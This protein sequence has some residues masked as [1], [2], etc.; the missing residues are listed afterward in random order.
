M[1]N[2]INQIIDKAAG[3]ESL[4][5]VYQEK[6]PIPLP[7][8]PEGLKLAKPTVIKLLEYALNERW[9][10]GKTQK[11]QVL[12]VSGMNPLTGIMVVSVEGLEEE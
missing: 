6:L 2:K 8:E 7:P 12:D 9:F 4:L 10:A 5:P 3:N 11:I 1:N